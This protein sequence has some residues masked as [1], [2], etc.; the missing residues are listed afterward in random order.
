MF[1]QFLIFGSTERELVSE[2]QHSAADRSVG[3]RGLC[4]GAF[5]RHAAKGAAAQGQ[6][7]R[8]LVIYSPRDLTGRAKK[9]GAFWEGKPRSSLRILI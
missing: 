4:Q 8:E 2:I 5:A 3:S 9:G 6:R 1:K 7:E